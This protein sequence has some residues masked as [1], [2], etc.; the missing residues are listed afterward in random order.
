MQSA[1]HAD[2]VSLVDLPV[3]IFEGLDVDSGLPS[4][5]GLSLWP[6]VTE[7]QRVPSRLLTAEGTLY[8]P[9]RRAAIQW[10]LKL[11][12]E[13]GTG[14]RRLYNLEKDPGEQ[15]DLAPTERRAVRFL[16]QE[17]RNTLTAAREG[18]QSEDVPID[19]ET[20]EELR[21]LGYV[22]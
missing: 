16:S 3:T 18:V 9:E 12:V 20:L 8:G 19:E 15:T 10:P 14:R 22:K 13:I 6:V 5:A 4:S 2:P 1:R 17:L 21:S 11:T 7:G